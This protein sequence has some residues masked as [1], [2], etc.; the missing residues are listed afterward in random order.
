MPKTKLFEILKHAHSIQSAPEDAV[1]T[2]IGILERGDVYKY[3]YIDSDG[4]YWYENKY[5]ENGK[6]VSEYEHIFGC[7][8]PHRSIRSRISKSA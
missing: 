2:L 1:L 5:F 3:V 8:E 6:F 4:Q 7:S